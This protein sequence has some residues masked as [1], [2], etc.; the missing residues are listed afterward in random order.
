LL[1]NARRMAPMLSSVMGSQWSACG[2]LEGWHAQA[3]RP[4]GD[5]TKKLSNAFKIFTRRWSSWR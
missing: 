2:R 1:I 4:M 3:Q 5:S